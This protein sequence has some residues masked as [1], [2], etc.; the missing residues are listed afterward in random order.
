MNIPMDD[1]GGVDIPVD[2]NGGT[3]IPMDDNGGV[4][5]PVGNSVVVPGGGNTGTSTDDEYEVLPVKRNN[6]PTGTI[7]RVKDDLR[8]NQEKVVLPTEKKPGTTKQIETPKKQPVKQAETPKKPSVKQVE[9]PKSQPINPD[10]EDTGIY[11]DDFGD[12]ITPTTPAPAKKKKEKE[13]EEI[14]LEDEYY[15]LEGF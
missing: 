5:I 12:D 13:L 4:D 14:D 11:F 15:D 2:D 1:N 6:N 10:K 8:T 9:T 3:N 7:P